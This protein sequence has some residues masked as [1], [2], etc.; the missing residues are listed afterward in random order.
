[1]WS[2]EE[3]SR[4]SSGHWF[5]FHGP[6]PPRQTVRPQAGSHSG[7]SVAHRQGSAADLGAP[8]HYWPQRAP[9]DMGPAAQTPE[10]SL[11]IR[12]CWCM[13]IIS[14]SFPLSRLL[15]PFPKPTVPLPFPCTLLPPDPHHERHFL[16]LSHSPTSCTSQL[17]A[18]V[19][20]C[21][22]WYFW[23]LTNSCSS[24][25]ELELKTQLV[26]TA[27]LSFSFSVTCWGTTLHIWL[28]ISQ[29]DPGVNFLVTLL[30]GFLLW[31]CKEWKRKGRGGEA[32]LVVTPGH[33]LLRWIKITF[34]FLLSWGWSGLFP[35]NQN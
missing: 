22:L 20:E 6:S 25:L 12:R 2:D 19:C 30:W 23:F 16:I 11:W 26:G 35:C 21:Q 29:T 10:S 34:L 17:W 9:V 5:P 32:P 8:S 24:P 27:V 28:T 3:G 4:K 7:W 18:V 33:N 15:L 1:M 31:Y 13:G 14:S